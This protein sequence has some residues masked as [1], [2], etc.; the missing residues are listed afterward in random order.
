MR[1]HILGFTIFTLILSSSIFVYWLIYSPAPEYHFTTEPQN[2]APSMPV[3]KPNGFAEDIYTITPASVVVDVNSKKVYAGI[4]DKASNLASKEVVKVV[5]FAENSGEVAFET[6]WLD[7]M[8]STN[9]VFSCD[10]CAAM[11]SKKNYYARVYF[12]AAPDDA[13][14]K[15]RLENEKSGDF[16]LQSTAVL[17][18]SGKIK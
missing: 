17:V 6:R 16:Y 13:N 18:N 10:E 5:I 12:A 1:K 3:V 7:Y 11:T 4:N 14:L 9:L 2:Y 8:E 15:L